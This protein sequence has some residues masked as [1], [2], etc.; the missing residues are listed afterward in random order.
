MDDQSMDQNGMNSNQGQTNGQM[1]QD[2]SSFSNPQVQG[3]MPND[4]AIGQVAPEQK[5]QNVYNFLVQI[6]QEK[7]GNNLPW[8]QITTEA[9]SLYEKLGDALVNTFEPEMSNENRDEFNNLVG[10][11]YKQ[12]DLQMYLL[13]NIPNLE[14]RITQIL[15]NFKATYLSS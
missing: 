2:M 13:Q 14:N 15:E 3:M 12:E 10:Q 8:D 6:I 1:P 7:R 4:P 9:D 11:G 5:D